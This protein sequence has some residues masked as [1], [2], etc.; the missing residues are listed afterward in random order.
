VKHGYLEERT[1]SSCSVSAFSQH[2]GESQNHGKGERRQR[3]RNLSGNRCPFFFQQSSTNSRLNF[4]KEL[5]MNIDQ[6]DITLTESF[7]RQACPNDTD[8]EIEQRLSI[9][10]EQVANHT[11]LCATEAAQDAINL[12]ARADQPD[13]TDD[14]EFCAEYVEWNE[15]GEV[16][17]RGW[18][19]HP[20][21]CAHCG[22]WGDEAHMASCPDYE[23]LDDKPAA[24]LCGISPAMRARF[25]TDIVAYDKGDTW[26]NLS[27]VKFSAFREELELLKS[28]G[29][30]PNDTEESF[31]P[32]AVC[33]CKHQI[34]TT[35]VKAVNGRKD[36]DHQRSFKL[37]SLC[38]H[39]TEITYLETSRHEQ[40]R[41]EAVKARTKRYRAG[42]RFA[43]IHRASRAGQTAPQ[44]N[45]SNAAHEL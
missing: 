3:G 2:K 33:G 11:A 41:I 4:N 27:P 6:H 7:W 17:A 36:W 38:F 9:R 40:E 15:S 30:V 20:D 43:A 23:H 10:R 25:V 34:S 26:A 35:Y 32:C 24:A 12:Q 5:I 28:Q 18:N 37:C 19:A 16:I 29:Y 42:G 21:R 22:A 31:I 45:T 39:V 14:E 8:A 13:D 1:V 44:P